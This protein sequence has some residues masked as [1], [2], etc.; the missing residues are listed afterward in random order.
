MRRFWYF[1]VSVWSVDKKPY[2]SGLCQNSVFTPYCKDWDLIYP[3]NLFKRLQFPWI[4]LRYLQ[5][6]LRLLPD[7]PRYPQ[8]TWNANR[9][10]QMPRNTARLS[11]TAPVSFLG[12]LAVSVGVCWHLLACHVPQ[13]CCGVIR[14]M[15]GGCLGEAEL[16][17]WKSEAHKCV[18]GVYGFSILAV[19]SENTILAQPWM[20]RFSVNWPYWDIKIPKPPHIS[21]PKMIGLGHFLQFLGSSERYYLL[22]LLLIALYCRKI[23]QDNRFH[24][25]HYHFFP[26]HFNF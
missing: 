7:T 12:S 14:R 20:V 2:H 6:P 11:Q 25:T 3:P 15:F 1:D 9:Q 4:P 22:Q 18:W 23:F 5:T 26:L 24:E 21:L 13:R 19:W 17:S 10:Q 8:G 16:N